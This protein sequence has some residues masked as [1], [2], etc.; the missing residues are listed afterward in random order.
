MSKARDWREVC[1]A[2]GQLRD[3]AWED[4]G[5]YLCASC[6]YDT[7]ALVTCDDCGTRYRPWSTVDGKFLCDKCEMHLYH[8]RFES[9][10]SLC[11]LERERARRE[12]DEILQKTGAEAT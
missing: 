4:A 1:A 3:V 10:C 7:K 12:A 9:R 8:E 11:I 5:K 2:C 6:R